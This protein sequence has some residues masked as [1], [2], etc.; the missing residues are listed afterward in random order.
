MNSDQVNPASLA[1]Y[2]RLKS[3]NRHVDRTVNNISFFKKTSWTK[4]FFKDAQLN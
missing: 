4:L 3:T 1:L 2:C